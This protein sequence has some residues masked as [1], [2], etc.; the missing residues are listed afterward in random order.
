MGRAPGDGR[1]VGAA[2]LV[3][4]VSLVLL[5]AGGL[6]ED[7]VQL[8]GPMASFN[9]AYR[10]ASGHWG[11]CSLGTSGC[12]DKVA[13]TGCLVTCFAMVLDYYQ[14]ELTIPAASSCT[15]RGET[16]MDPGILNDWLQTHRGYGR[17][18]QD[19]VGN[20]CLEWDNLPP[21]ISLAFYENLATTGLDRASRT[22]ID[23]ALAKGYPVVA[24]V[25]W[26]KTCHGGRGTE[27]CHW[28]VLTGKTKETYRI[29]DPYNRDT[30]SRD[31]V[32]TTL[33]KGVFGG[34]TIDRYVI[35]SGPVPVPAP[36]EPSL[37][38]TFEPAGEAV[39]IGEIQRR[40]VEVEDV[41]RP[42]LLFA[43]AIDSQGTVRYAHYLT[44]DPDPSAPLLLSLDRESVYPEPRRFGPEP[45]EWGRA[46]IDAGEEGAWTW[47]VWVEDPDVPG[48]PLAYDVAGYTVLSPPP[49]LPPA[50][51]SIAVA[52]AVGLALLVTALVYLGAL[53]SAE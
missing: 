30:A 40:L 10:D 7:L 32:R 13:S 18:A 46:A 2:G 31:G 11:L 17:C 37:E 15:G 28:V 35:V 49:T 27:D 12:P 29:H 43:R 23:R 20:C 34:Y 26:G 25:H 45:R 8:P 3:A 19:P 39:R 9:Q 36:T 44:S 14:V 53:S 33:A 51:P 52:L 5:S 41:A 42:V 16:G 24:G 1:R 21:A 47:E 38:V 50:A 4:V 22:R 48:E 6:A